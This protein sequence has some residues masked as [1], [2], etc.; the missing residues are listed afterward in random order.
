MKTRND[1]EIACDCDK[2]ANGVL[3]LGLCK[4]IFAGKHTATHKPTPAQPFTVTTMTSNNR[5]WS[6]KGLRPNGAIIRDLTLQ[7]LEHNWWTFSLSYFASVYFC[8]LFLTVDRKINRVQTPNES[9][10]ILFSA[11]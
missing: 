6:P 10:L 2:R 7:V 8:V 11:M 1:C 3:H 4:E 9:S 5:L